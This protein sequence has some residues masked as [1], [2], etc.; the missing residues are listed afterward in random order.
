MYRY[1]LYV[2]INEDLLTIMM[3][4]SLSPEYENIRVA[5]ESRD[6]LPK[7]EELRTKIIE[8]CEARHSKNMTNDDEAESLAHEEEALYTSSKICK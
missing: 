1:K 2:R 7:Q 4:Y 5:I 3:L 8:E 6:I